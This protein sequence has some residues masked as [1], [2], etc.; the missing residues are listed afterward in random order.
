[1]EQGLT[2]ITACL[3]NILIEFV[4]KAALG[5]KYG[6]IAY[7]LVKSTFGFS[8]LLIARRCGARCDRASFRLFT[9]KSK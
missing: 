2:K 8:L 1:M 3:F 5:T 4:H 6:L 9:T 7:T